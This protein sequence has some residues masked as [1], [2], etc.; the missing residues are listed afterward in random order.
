M[1]QSRFKFLFNY[2][3]QGY[4]G[5]QRTVDQMS[6]NSLR[7]KYP[8]VLI[9][10]LGAR[11]NFGLV[12]YFYG[13]PEMLRDA[14]NQVITPSLT[15]WHTI[16]FRAAQLKKQ[17]ERA[18]PE[19]KVNLVGHSMGGLDARYLT[20]QLGFADRVA[21]LTTIGTPHRGTSVSDLAVESLPAA[22]FQA[23]DR[24][25]KLMDSN[26]GGTSGALTQI[27]R[28]SRTGPLALDAP[29]ISGV[30]YYSATTAIT[31]PLITK[32]LPIFWLSH[33]ILKKSEGDNDGFVSVESATWGEPI[34]TYSGD[35][36]AQIGQIL[37]RARG[38]DYLK[39]YAEIFKRLKRDG[40]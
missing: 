4:N 33:Q 18:I 37:G 22:T 3:V 5:E 35:H 8:I 10:G 25:L 16:E 31:N 30:A 21:S 34:C 28:R 39:F 15:A 6:S 27:T 20:S 36:Y 2:Q 40:M 26:S 1:N 29:N 12:N 23:V 19:G 38:M 13:L 24:L 11:S 9:H 17:I 7:L 14:Q 32:A